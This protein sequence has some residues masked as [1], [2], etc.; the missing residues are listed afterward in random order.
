MT[1]PPTAGALIT[2]VDEL[3]AAPDLTIVYGADG[4]LY[5]RVGYPPGWPE[6]WWTLDSRRY[7]VAPES[8]PLHAI[9]VFHPDH[10]PRA[11]RPPQPH[12][13]EIYQVRKA[14]RTVAEAYDTV[15]ALY[16]PNYP[17]THPYPGSNPERAGVGDPGHCEHCAV[18]GHVIAHPDLGCDDVACH[19][20]HAAADD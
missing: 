17:P 8:I 6:A 4:K 11:P 3:L 18:F 13:G 1:T 20:M 7:Q 10:P 14:S 12:P 19:H 5:Q 9:V 2:S 16:A 15:M